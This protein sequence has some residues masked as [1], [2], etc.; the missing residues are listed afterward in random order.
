MPALAR[1]VLLLIVVAFL[2]NLARGTE[3]TW[4]RAKFLGRAPATSA[5]KAS[6]AV[7]GSPAVSL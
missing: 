6:G 3:R 5:K 1:T 7:Q 4:L 2:W